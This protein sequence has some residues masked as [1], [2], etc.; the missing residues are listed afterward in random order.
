MKKTYSISFLVIF[1]LLLFSHLDFAQVTEP[2]VRYQLFRL[3]S[4]ASGTVETPVAFKDT[5]DLGKSTRYTLRVTYLSSN[6]LVNQSN[7]K[8]VRAAQVPAFVEWTDFFSDAGWGGTFDV[9]F[10]INTQ[11]NVPKTGRFA[12]NIISQVLKDNS[13]DVQLTDTT[14]FTVWVRPFIK[15]EPKFS[16]GLSNTI[17]WYPSQAPFSQ[18]IISSSGMVRLGKN[19]DTRYQRET[20]FNNLSDG[21]RYSYFV[22]T[23]LQT[24]AGLVELHSDT[25]YSTQD[26]SPPGKVTLDSVISYDLRQVHLYWKGTTDAISFVKAYNIYRMRDNDSLTIHFIAT[27][28][29]KDTVGADD[30]SYVFVDYPMDPP[31]E[32]FAYQVR[33]V[34]AVGNEGSGEFSGPVAKL[35]VPE[36]TAWY[37]WSR[38]DYSWIDYYKQGVT[39]TIFV[40][41]IRP[42]NENQILYLPDS[43]RFQA[44]RDSL[45]YFPIRWE[46]GKQ[47]FESRYEENGKTSA[48]IPLSHFAYDSIRYTFDLSNNGQN[49]GNYINHHRYHFRVQYKDHF[50]NYSAWSDTVWE[51]QDVFPPEDID[52][53][54]IHPVVVGDTAG[55]MLLSWKKPLDS[56]TGVAYYFVYRKIGANG[57][58]TLIDTTSLTRYEDPFASVGTN[59]VVFYKVGSIDHVGNERKLD[60]IQD[61][62]SAQ[63]LAGPT[64][65]VLGEVISY[66]GN[67]YTKAD[68][69]NFYWE[70][71]IKDDIYKYEVHVT[72]VVDSSFYLTDP[73]VSNF[74]WA[75]PRLGRY[76]VRVR[77]IYS[78]GSQSIWSRPF[79]VT[80]AGPPSDFHLTVRNDSLPA[81]HVFLNWQAN[82]EILPVKSYEIYRWGIGESPVKIAAIQMDTTDYSIPTEFVD[83]DTTVPNYKCLH[84]RVTATNL[85]DLDKNSTVDSSYFNRAPEILPEKTVVFPGKMTIFWRRPSPNLSSNWGNIV[86]IFREKDT[87]PVKIDTVFGKKS[88]SFYNPE[89]GFVY[90]FQVK[91]FPAVVTSQMCPNG[92]LETAWSAEETIPYIKYPPIQDVQAQALPAA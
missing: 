39:N 31:T 61:E 42:G 13:T 3:D 85:L 15:E 49:D 1:V 83:A 16:Q 84:Y 78:V 65:K 82:T 70:N 89:K 69:L 4:T 59:D 8:A 19:A 20:V 72:G 74:I 86:R 55:Y 81:G 48:W 32:S 22:K 38:P 24:D 11:S 56:V 53:D 35:P 76:S 46:P 44:I 21:Q 28:P 64:L 2:F 30:S 18:E 34:D 17:V 7:D 75:M 52:L 66:E 25:V 6:Y 36:I 92:V 79:V 37:D 91:E 27:V 73:S 26:A 71:Y 45:K 5:V 9:P 80:K 29:A 47:F 43:I 67:L 68:A 10:T 63:C 62:E 51:R 87:I 41:D 88:Y 40:Q 90:R 58:Y 33:A 12:F 57:T 23:L 50:G 54:I 77:A 60:Q 14:R